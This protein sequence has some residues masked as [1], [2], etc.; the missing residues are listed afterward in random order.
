MTKIKFKIIM[1]LLTLI[2]FTLFFN[3]I[4]Y[5]EKFYILETGSIATGVYNDIENL[6]VVQVGYGYRKKNIY[7]QVFGGTINQKHSTTYLFSEIGYWRD[8]TDSLYGKISLG[9]GYVN[10]TDDYLSSHNMFT[11]S[12]SIGYDNFYISYRHMSNGGHQLG[13]PGPN[14]GRNILT[15]GVIYFFKLKTITIK[16]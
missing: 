4:S 6:N 10:N 3:N 13:N 8:F 16:K 5:A 15:F 7:Y 14:K 2:L 9:I 12:I 11:E 1:T